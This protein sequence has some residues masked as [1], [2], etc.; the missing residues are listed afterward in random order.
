MRCLFEIV[1]Y[2]VQLRSVPT[3][4]WV[5]RGL[6]F[7]AHHRDHDGTTQRW[8]VMIF[9]VISDRDDLYGTDVYGVYASSPIANSSF[10]VP[11]GANTSTLMLLATGDFSRYVVFPFGSVA[12]RT[13]ILGTSLTYRFSSASTL[14][15]AL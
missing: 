15:L 14:S 6:S 1:S 7:A 10:S 13:T 5:V 12:A 4:F 8:N 11:F 9:L 2:V 3:L